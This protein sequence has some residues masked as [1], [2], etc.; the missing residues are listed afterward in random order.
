M[1]RDDATLSSLLE[2][3]NTFL[4]KSVI[5]YRSYV[6]NRKCPEW[7]YGVVAVLVSVFPPQQTRD[8]SEHIASHIEMTHRL[9]ELHPFA[10][11]SEA[12]VSSFFDG[13]FTLLKSADAGFAAVLGKALQGSAG[14]A[15]A[16]YFTPML[17]QL[18]ARYLP[19]PCVTFLWDQILI[20]LT[21]SRGPLVASHYV[22]TLFLCVRDS[23][24]TCST[25]TMTCDV[26]LSLSQFSRFLSTRHSFRVL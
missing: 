24:M 23:L 4:M 12:D 15:L 14:K 16:H 6:G 19:L 20:G 10:T 18:F 22:A 2:S 25:V 9:I 7:E 21:C 1:L 13:V 5:A 17:L 8:A 3:A 26:A 11:M